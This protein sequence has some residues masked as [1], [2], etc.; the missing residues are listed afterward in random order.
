[1]YW[2]W[3]HRRRTHCRHRRNRWRK[4]ASRCITLVGD[5]LVAGVVEIEARKRDRRAGRDGGC[6]RVAD[7]AFAGPETAG[8]QPAIVS[9]TDDG[10]GIDV[11]QGHE[12]ETIRTA[13]LVTDNCDVA[14]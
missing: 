11:T 6:G 2:R 7:R 1:M 4:G 10:A 9:E 14:D 3:W 13:A 12:C 5:D 8:G